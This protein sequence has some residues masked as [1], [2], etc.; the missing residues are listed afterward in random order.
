M[1]TRLDHVCLGVADVREASDRWRLQFGLT[2]RA[3][4]VLA[5]DDEPCA[6]ELVEGERGFDH[7]AYELAG[8]LDEALLLDDP[9]V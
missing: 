1:I 2:E 7:V 3:P 5:C 8:S 4:G 6:V 9:H